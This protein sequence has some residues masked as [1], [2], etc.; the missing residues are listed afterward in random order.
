MVRY[1]TD[2]HQVGKAAAEAEQ[3]AGQVATM[4]AEGKAAAEKAQAL[5]RMIVE[6][7]AVVS[8]VSVGPLLSCGR[9][10]THCGH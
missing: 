3:L 8:V 4:E 7:G 5:G 2:V 6:V 1:A 9:S 10:L